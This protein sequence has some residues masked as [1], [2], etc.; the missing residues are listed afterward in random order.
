MLRSFFEAIFGPAKKARA[1]STSELRDALRHAING[2]NRPDGRPL[3]SRIPDDFWEQDSFAI[4]FPMAATEP[5][6]GFELGFLD[7]VR[8]CPTPDD[9]AKL[10][11]DNE[12]GMQIWRN[13]EYGDGG[14]R[15]DAAVRAKRDLFR[16]CFNP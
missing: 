4:G 11:M 12:R 2:T 6:W 5:E 16:C 9:L 13:F 7:A 10:I 14:A 1:K 8:F 15:I 3:L